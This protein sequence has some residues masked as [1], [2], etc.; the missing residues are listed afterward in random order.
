M[1]VVVN[2]FNPS[3]SRWISTIEANQ[4]YIVKTVSKKKK[5]GKDP[6]KEERILYDIQVLT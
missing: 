5:K 4:D 6:L 3:G 1:V 2:V